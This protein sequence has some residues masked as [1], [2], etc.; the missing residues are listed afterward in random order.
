[1]TGIFAVP[2]M[3]LSLLLLMIMPTLG[4]FAIP[5]MVGYAEVETMG[6]EL[7]RAINSVI[8]APVVPSF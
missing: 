2:T 5:E 1:M 7:N 8:V 6:M 3:P 4:V